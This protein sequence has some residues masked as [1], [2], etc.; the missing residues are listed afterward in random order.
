[1]DSDD[2][3]TKS[4]SI[5]G[6]SGVITTSDVSSDTSNSHVTN[7]TMTVDPNSS[8]IALLQ[9]EI[10]RKR[11][12][13]DIE[14][15]RRKQKMDELRVAHQIDIENRI[16][17]FAEADALRRHKIMVANENQHWMKAFWRPAMGWCWLII[18]L[19][20]FVLAPIMM[21][22]IPFFIKGA[23]YTPWV[24]L[25]G[26]NGGMIHLAFGAVLGVTSWTKG[27]QNTQINGLLNNVNTPNQL[28]P[29][30]SRS[31]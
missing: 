1:M 20:D 17:D 12:L 16:Q 25:T 29:Q 7:T 11:L 22:M 3:K 18:C 23:S 19:F 26:S 21:A 13:A 2:N 10:D 28:I 5:S 14:I 8:S 31:N 27:Q 15:E 9:A 4:S 24:S 6:V 30:S